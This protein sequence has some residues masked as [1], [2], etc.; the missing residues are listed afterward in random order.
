MKIHH[1]QLLG[2]R[3]DSSKL[4]KTIPAIWYKD[5][6]FVCFTSDGI[7]A[8]V[9][10]AGHYRSGYADHEYRYENEIPV[11]KKID[12]GALVE[13]HKHFVGGIK[14]A[15]YEIYETPYVDRVVSKLEGN[16]QY[17]KTALTRIEPE[18]TID[19]VWGR[20]VWNN[21]NIIESHLKEIG[22]EITNYPWDKMPYFT[23]L[24][25]GEVIRHE[26]SG[27]SGQVPASLDVS[28]LPGVY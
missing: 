16:P 23:Y 27:I 11:F 21:I 22:A 5:G 19:I 18:Y 13:Y 9:S 6:E 17:F 24:Y 14:E 26:G 8:N 10:L 25:E 12:Y 2:E 7:D 4:I 15:Y 1:D 20:G 3:T 28:T